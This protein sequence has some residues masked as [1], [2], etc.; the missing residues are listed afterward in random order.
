MWS[1]PLRLKNYSYSGEHF[2]KKQSCSVSVCSKNA[3]HTR[4]TQPSAG[5]TNNI[6]NAKFAVSKLQAFLQGFRYAGSCAVNNC[7]DNQQG[8]SIM[9]GVS[10]FQL[11]PGNTRGAFENLLVGHFVQLDIVN[12]Q[13]FI[14]GFHMSGI[15]SRKG[16]HVSFYYFLY[17]ND[18][19]IIL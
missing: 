8:I 10:L 5:I 2:D 15:D 19:W 13:L 6:Q 9:S 17:E 11:I 3:M 12:S 4:H 16:S 18:S 7:G 1:L 14:P